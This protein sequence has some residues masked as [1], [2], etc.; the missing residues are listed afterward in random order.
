VCARLATFPWFDIAQLPPFDSSEVTTQQ[1]EKSIRENIEKYW[2][3]RPHA[4]VSA[5]S[6]SAIEMQLSLGC[7]HLILPSPLIE[8]RED[9]AQEQAN[10]LDASIEAANELD[11]GQALLAT[12]AI[13]ESVLTESAFAT[14][15]FLDAV[16]D[17]YTAREGVQGVYIVVV[18]TSAG[19]PFETAP[20]VLRCYA[21]LVSAFKRAGVGTII[22]NFADTFGLACTGLGATSFATGHSQSVRR[23]SVAGFE[24]RSGGRAYPQFYSNRIV[25]EL[26]TEQDLDHVVG[27]GLLGRVRDLTTY[28]QSLI[29]ELERG[30]SARDV[31]LWAEGMN[32]TA[33]SH[34]H[35]VS[36]MLKESRGLAKRSDAAN[37][38][39][40][41]EWLEEA[42]AS[43]EFLRRR[44]ER[45]DVAIKGKLAPAEEWLDCYSK[46]E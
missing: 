23:L 3:A 30:G 7:T 37:K 20:A 34:K 5:A 21:H 11:V 28:S 19:H 36:R 24:D 27:M 44:F 40:C 42:A 29:E 8:D 41:H 38:R 35:F 9:E 10:W 25:G 43:G 26:Y 33:Q 16:V 31:P 45:R 39:F 32:N 22:T 1:W 14:G 18:Q 15:G 17:Q 4:D 6:T 13:S 12:V 2:R 46:Y